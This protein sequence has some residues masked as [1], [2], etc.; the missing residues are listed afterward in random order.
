MKHNLGTK[1]TEKRLIKIRDMQ[2]RNSDRITELALQKLN[3]KTKNM[4]GRTR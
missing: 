2:L 4:K 3:K 1:N